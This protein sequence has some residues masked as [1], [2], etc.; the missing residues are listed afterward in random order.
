MNTIKAWHFLP[1]DGC[2]RYG[3]KE[4]VEVGKTITIDGP[5]KLCEKGLHGSR[6]VRDALKYSPGPT[7]CRVEIWGDVEEQG[8]K[9][10]GRNR[11][12][13]Q[14]AD[15]TSTLLEFA[16]RCAEHAL[17]RYWHRDDDRPYEAIAAV[18]KYIIGESVDLHAAADAAANATNAA[19]GRLLRV[20][21]NQ[22]FEKDENYG[23]T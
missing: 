6:S 13:L 8:D 3:T 18:R 21:V 15:A 17:N 10:A 16:C 7:V 12:V 11:R 14:M 23:K 1:K 9:L 19:Q 20:M 4:K 5:I 22:L 2:L